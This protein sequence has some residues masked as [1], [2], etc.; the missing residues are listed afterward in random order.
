MSV[1]R[2]IG[3]LVLVVSYN[4]IL[5]EDLIVMKYWSLYVHDRTL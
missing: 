2:T 4:G 1:Y 3:P 5:S